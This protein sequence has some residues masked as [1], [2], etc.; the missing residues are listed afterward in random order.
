MNN[1]ILD[2]ESDIKFKREYTEEFENKITQFREYEYYTSRITIGCKGEDYVVILTDL[3]TS[4]VYNFGFIPDEWILDALTQFDKNNRFMINYSDKQLKHD[5]GSIEKKTRINQQYDSFETNRFILNK[6]ISSFV[7][8]PGKMLEAV[9]SYIEMNYNIEI[10]I[11]SSLN[12]K[13]YLLRLKRFYG[14][15]T[16]MLIDGSWLDYALEQGHLKL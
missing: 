7:S 2:Y 10:D 1:T 5:P 3:E 11:A 8:T 12:A 6:N 16:T 4:S 9:F 15:N 13:Q 14:Y